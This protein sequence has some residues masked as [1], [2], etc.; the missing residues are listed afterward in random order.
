VQTEGRVITLKRRKKSIVQQRDSVE[1]FFRQ[2][3]NG[4]ACPY[5]SAL[6]RGIAAI[7]NCKKNAERQH[8]EPPPEVRMLIRK[9]FGHSGRV[10]QGIERRSG[11]DGA[12]D[13][14]KQTDKVPD[15]F[16][17]ASLPEIYIQR[18]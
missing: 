15:G 2:L 14:K 16:H 11:N 3:G 17:I 18:N 1:N 9:D 4:A 6:F 12:Y 5:I 13:C 8:K 7:H 10:A